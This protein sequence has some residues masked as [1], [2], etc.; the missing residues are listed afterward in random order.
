MLQSHNNNGYFHILNCNGKVSVLNY[1]LRNESVWGRGGITPHINLGTSLGWD[2]SFWHWL[3]YRRG[4]TLGTHLMVGWLSPTACP[5]V[6]VARKKS[7]TP[8]NRTSIAQNAAYSQQRLLFKKM[9]QN[10]WSAYELGAHPMAIESDPAPLKH[11][12]TRLFLWHL[13]A[14]TCKAT[15]IS[16]TNRTRHKD[17]QLPFSSQPVEGQLEC[18][19]CQY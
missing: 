6:A 19:K 14:G 5:N 16:G 13:S 4:K 1:A 15:S 10:V 11:T 2:V 9:I 18:P 12:Q 17:N 8:R 7:A 3:L